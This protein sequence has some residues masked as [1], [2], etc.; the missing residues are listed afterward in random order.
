MG[1]PNGQEY[2]TVVFPEGTPDSFLLTQQH[3]Q[4]A[5]GLHHAC[6]PA[7]VDSVIMSPPPLTYL[8][9]AKFPDTG[10]R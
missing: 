1:N 3:V 2:G 6:S 7:S 8:L 4:A 9:H 10:R 5:G